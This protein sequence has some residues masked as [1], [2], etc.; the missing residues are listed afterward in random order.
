M[1]IAS[2]DAKPICNMCKTGCSTNEFVE[3]YTD[4]KVVFHPDTKEIILA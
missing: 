3:C 2:G 1:I 4:N